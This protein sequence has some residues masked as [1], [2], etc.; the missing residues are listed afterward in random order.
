VVMNH[1][2]LASGG[3]VDEGLGLSGLTGRVWRLH[4]TISGRF[5]DSDAEEAAYLEQGHESRDWV[6]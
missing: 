2:T 4:E 3:R 5:D 1:G 6:G